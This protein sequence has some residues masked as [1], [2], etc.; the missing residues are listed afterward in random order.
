[1]GEIALVGLGALVCFLGVAALSPLLSRPVARLVGA[2]FSRGVPGRLGRLNAMRNPQRTASTAAA[3]MIGLALVTAVGVLG[4]SAKASVEQVVT[5]SVGADVVVQGGGFQGFPSAVAGVLERTEGVAA[6]DRVR[7]DQAQVGDDTTFLTALSPDAIG[8]GVRLVPVDGELV[9]GP[10]VLLVSEGEATGNDLSVGDQVSVRLSRGEP[11]ELTVAGV[12]EDS[13]LVGP[14]VLDLTQAEDFA[15]P[16]DAALLLT[17]EDGVDTA[18]LVTAAE[19]ATVDYPTVEVLDQAAFIEDTTSTIDVVISIINVLLALSVLI[20]VLGIVNTLA[21]AVLERTREL[22]LLRAVGL[23]RRQTRR[24]VTVEAVIVAI[25]GALLGI[26]VGSVFGVVLQRALADE[27]ITE[28]R[29][30]VGRLVLFVV[31]AALAGVVAAL[32]P[33]RRAARLDVLKAIATT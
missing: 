12:Y 31:V 29:F 19:A 17:A 3:L 23:G 7:Q 13:E 33:A 26:G 32:L 15:S 11:R 21:L 6:V 4:A 25:F 2:P 30:P 18:T 20:A 5:A 22:G 10:G 28:L 8:R 14:Y 27:G 24:M 9:P 16:T 1:Q